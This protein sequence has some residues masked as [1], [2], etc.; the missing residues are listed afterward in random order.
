MARVIINIEDPAWGLDDIAEEL[1]EVA[2]SIE[3]GYSGGLTSFGNGWEL[4][5]FDW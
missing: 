2:N 5:D 4:E 3:D 1:R